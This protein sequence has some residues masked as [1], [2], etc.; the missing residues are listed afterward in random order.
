MPTAIDL[1]ELPVAD[2]H[3]HGLHRDHLVASPVEGWDE[4]LTLMGMCLESS[5]SADPRMAR[6]LSSLTDSTVL[7]LVARRWLAGHLGCDVADVAEARH[8]ALV[9][10]IEA[11]VGGLLAAEQVTDLF[12]DDGYPRPVVAPSD[13]AHLTGARVHPVRRIELMIEDL[14]GAAADAEALEAAFRDRLEGAF[15]DP[16]CVAVKTVIAYRTGLDVTTPTRK[17]VQAAFDGWRARGWAEDRDVAKPVRDHLLHVTC[18]VAAANDRAVHIHS[19]AG[20]P[21]VRLS[22][23]RPTGLAPLLTAHADTA[24]VLIHAGY[25]W[26]EDATYLAAIYS[27]AFLDLSLH[28]PWATLDADR[29]ITTALGA[30]PTG[31]VMYGSDEASEPEILWLSARMARDSLSRVLG[32]AVD[33]DMLTTVEAHRIGGAV[34]AGTALRLH[35]VVG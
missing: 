10:D 35:G 28:L 24:I 23:A 32:R 9:D 6:Q 4:R 3:C 8:R 31:K 27:N 22:H 19:G 25:P 14:R 1:T 21:D 15:E 5:A 7:A 2:V 26:I 17:E 33:R 29:I 13:F 18:E 16:A 11:Y 34:L 30:A 12:V 20:D